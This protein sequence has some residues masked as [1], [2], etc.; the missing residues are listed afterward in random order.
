[1]SSLSSAY[2]NN[3]FIYDY[4]NQYF[5]EGSKIDNNINIFMKN[6]FFTERVKKID[7]VISIR[8]TTVYEKTNY[9][10][11]E[12]VFNDFS[13]NFNKKNNYLIKLPDINLFLE[14]DFTNKNQINN[15]IQFPYL[16]SDKIIRPFLLFLETNREFKNNDFFK[17]YIYPFLFLITLFVFLF[18][19]VNSNLIT[20]FLVIKNEK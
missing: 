15:F 14:T 7:N 9:Y 17:T 1:M 11:G 16:H 18:L 3:F 12:F 10:D 6:K 8:S 2:A 19:L 4:Q 20:K 13:F 5:Y